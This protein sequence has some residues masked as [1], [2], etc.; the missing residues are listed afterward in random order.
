MTGRYPLRYGLQTGVIPSAHTYGLPIDE[1]LLPQALKEAGYRTAIT[2]S[3]IWATRAKLI[4]RVSA[5]LITNTV[6]SSARLITSPT[7]S[8]A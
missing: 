7:S 8:T 2:A 4:G 3:G 6:R 1:W 5:G